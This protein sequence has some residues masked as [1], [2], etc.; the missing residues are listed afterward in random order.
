METGVFS[1]L[2]PHSKHTIIHG[3]VN[4][5]IPR[6]QSYKRKIYD[7]KIVK[8]DQI[9]ENLLNLNW[10]DLFFNLNGHEK[11]LVFSVLWSSTFRTEL[12]LAMIAMPRG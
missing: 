8:T 1:S 10:H 3:S 2:D 5:G 9:R 4:V 12:S 11:A 7:Y 6:P